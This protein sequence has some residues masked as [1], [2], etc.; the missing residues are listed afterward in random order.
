MKWINLN[1]YPVTFAICSN[2]EEFMK[3][4][5]RYDLDAIS[6]PSGI[7]GRMVS[8]LDTG[9]QLRLIIQVPDTFVKL[10]TVCKL[11]TLSHEIAHAVLRTWEYLGESSPGQEANA[12][13]TDY[14]TEYCWMQ[15]H[16]IK[17]R[18]KDAI[19]NKSST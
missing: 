18:K 11:T 13:L 12:Y 14:I 10:K 16:P 1:P 3:H 19:S 2:N 7:L 8:Y 15:L 5:K 6:M 9:N 17:K 4:T